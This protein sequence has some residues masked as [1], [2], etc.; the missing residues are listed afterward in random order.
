MYSFKEKKIHFNALRNP[1]AVKY[2][3]ELLAREQ[4]NFS[5]LATFRRNPQRNSDN[6][7]YALL[8]CITRERIREYRR[9]RMEEDAKAAS[10]GEAASTANEEKQESQIE[11]AEHSEEKKELQEEVESRVEEAEA[12]AEEAE[13]A[14][15]EVE[16]R[17]EEAEAR[18]EEA[19]A[20]AEEAEEG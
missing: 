2:D 9:T 3:L 11:T 16:A 18:A 10:P 17:V 13:E 8:D 15:E 6:I 5:H 20:R 7:L 14:Q 4:P 19:E 12:R 1:D